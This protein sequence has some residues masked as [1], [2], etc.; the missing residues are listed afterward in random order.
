MAAAAVSQA[1][2]MN[3]VHVAAAT[4]P[5]TDN[6]AHA[7]P[8]P[9]RQMGFTTVTQIA[10]AAGVICLVILHSIPSKSGVPRAMLLVGLGLPSLPS[11]RFET[12]TSVDP[13]SD[14]VRKRFTEAAASIWRPFDVLSIE[15]RR[16]LDRVSGIGYSISPTD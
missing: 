2:I 9:M 7:S 5:N 1:S 12:S 13:P 4:P 10:S 15:L 11:L 14:C 3:I 8:P 16:H 6:S